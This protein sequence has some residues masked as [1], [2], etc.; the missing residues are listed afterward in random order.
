MFRSFRID[1]DY[2][3]RQ[4]SFDLVFISRRFK[5]SLLVEDLKKI[6]QTYIKQERI[7]I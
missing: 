4:V 1:L 2:L 6:I 5:D 3:V 7:I